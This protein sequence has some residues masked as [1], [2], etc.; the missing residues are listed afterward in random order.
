MFPIMGEPQ[1]P[2]KNISN[3]LDELT[4]AAVRAWWESLW[5]ERTGRISAQVLS[6]HSMTLTHALNPF[7]H[8]VSEPASMYASR[9][10]VRSLHRPRRR[11]RES[12]AA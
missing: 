6:E 5:A 8:H 2:M 12:A 7:M 9:P 11:P 3:S 1:R 4:S 10:R